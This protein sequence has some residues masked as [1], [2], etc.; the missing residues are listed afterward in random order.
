MPDMSSPFIIQ[1]STLIARCYELTLG[2]S[3]LS[4]AKISV[5]LKGQALAEALFN[6]HLAILSH[7]VVVRGNVRD[8]AYNYANKTALEL[9]ERSFEEQ[10]QLLST[11]SAD[12]DGNAQSQRN[13]LL[14][15]CLMKGYVRFSGER[16]SASGKTVILENAVLFNLFDTAGVYCGQAVVFEP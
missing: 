4:R 3:L 10:T 2:E 5:E 11:R 8:N 12:S 7:E 6:C 14:A 16:L 13:S 9:F 1:Q 15:E